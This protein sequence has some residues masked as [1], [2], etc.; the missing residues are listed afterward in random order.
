MPS[1]GYLFSS[2]CSFVIL[3]NV[4]VQAQLNFAPAVVYPSGTGDVVISVAIS[5]LN[6]DGEP[7]VVTAGDDEV[8]VLLGNGDGTLKTPVGYYSGGNGSDYE[9]Y[10]VAVADLNGDGKPDIVVA[11][12]PGLIGVLLGNGDGTF[13]RTVS[14]GSGGWTS[15]SVAVADVNGDGKP[16][17][18]VANGCVSFS[19]CSKSSV[20]VLLGNGDGTFQPAIT[21]PSG[22]LFPGSVVIADVNNDGR[23]DVLVTMC[24][25]LN[26]NTA[27]VHGAVAV[28]L[29]KGDGTFRR[30]L[31]Q[32]V[33]LSPGSLAVA[34]VNGDGKADLLVTGCVLTPICA[35]VIAEFLG[36]GD[37]TFEA[38]TYFPT[39][40]GSVVAADMNGDGK[41]DLVVS[42]S[43]PNCADGYNGAVGVLLGNGNGR[44]QPAGTF[45]SGGY[46]AGAVAVTD[47]NGDGKPD[48]V[49]TTC[50]NSL[51]V[52]NP[53]VGVL[54]N[55]SNSAKKQH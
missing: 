19:D 32:Q 54:I 31:V 27:C 10:S 36:K 15:D 51:C 5:D 12:I 25:D 3:V 18:I 2:I 28:L 35:G 48:I 39:N 7:D 30:P 33:A 34:D 23:P 26:V 40:A 42:T 17:L 24:T 1:R 55:T 37:G 53:E 20:G 13:G 8:G 44:F 46:R 16:D 49:V 41:L 52:P 38:P 43:C 14:Y 6:G 21:F 9:A 45:P 47:L 22:G 50:D 29:G 4:Q 11:N